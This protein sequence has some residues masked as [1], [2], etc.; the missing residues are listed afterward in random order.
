MIKKT[1]NSREE[2][3]G[4]QTKLR[5]IDK[6]YLYN[7]IQGVLNLEKGFLLTVKNLL[8]KPGKSV[9]EFLFEDRKKYVKPILFLVFTSV[10]FSFLIKSLDISF[11]FFNIDTIKGL[12][13]KL[14]SREIGAWTQ[15]NLGYS[16]LI[17]GFFIGFWVK[18]LYRKS[19]YNLYE[20]LVLLSY[21]LG[22]G[23]IILGF[24]ILLATVLK[25]PIIGLIGIV[26]YFI[27]I[28]WG[29]GQFYGEN[30]AKNYLKSFLAYFLG[31]ATYLIA[32]IL[33]GYVLKF[34]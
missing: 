29:I 23:F 22:E 11:N 16:Q 20:I 25:G 8:I 15:G 7:E 19:N 28:I 13:G 5:R 21:L 10:I 31:N 3:D 14:R 32:L 1:K 30:Q 26:I 18:L 24:F 33:L 27:Y 6:N 17:M 4:I 9:R 2:K 12:K 34:I